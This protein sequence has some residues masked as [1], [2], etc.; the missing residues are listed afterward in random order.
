MSEPR[1]RTAPIKATWYFDV[2]SPFAY[3]QSFDLE[4]LPSSVVVEPVP[5]LFAGLLAHHGQTGNAEIPSKRRFTYRLCQWQ[6]ESRGLPLVFP[7]RHPFNPLA[8]LRLLTAADA[9]VAALRAAFACVW[10]TGA[11]PESPQTL[12]AVASALDAGVPAEEWLAR[13]RTAPVK[14]ALRA[15][16]ERAIGQGVFGVPT[17]VV[18]G[19]L[20]WGTD[21]FG[22]L[23]AYLADPALFRRPA[24]ARLES[25]PATHRRGIGA[26]DPPGS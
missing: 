19:E 12:Q 9:G 21:A 3:L 1:G 17:F 6:A 14:A 18:D 20:F 2:V 10:Q 25:L 23:L 13:S 16:T 4:R 15:A 26:G 8:I 22:M 7:A 5:V 11:D 24:M